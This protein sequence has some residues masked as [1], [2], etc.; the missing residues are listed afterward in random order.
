MEITN[1]Y[2][3]LKR[4]DNKVVSK[5]SKDAHRI[6]ITMPPSFFKLLES[7]FDNVKQITDPSLSQ[8]TSQGTFVVDYNG[9]KVTCNYVYQFVYSTCY[10][11]VSVDL[12]KEI[13]IEVLDI[14]NLKLL[15]LK[16]ELNKY[17]ISIISYDS[18]SEFYCDKLYPFFNEF[19][20]KLRN[21]L[22]LIYTTNFSLNYYLSTT[23]KELQ[24]KISKGTKEIKKDFVNYSK[25]EAKIKFA[26]YTL[27]YSDIENLL[28][29]EHVLDDDQIY[30][31]QF[32]K[33]DVD[34]S[35]L[36]EEQIRLIIN[37]GIIKSDWD[38]YF[39]DKFSTDFKSVLSNL[40]KYSNSI[41]HCKFVTK[42]Q[43]N[44]CLKSIKEAIKTVDRA[45][46]LT[47]ENDFKSKNVTY[48]TGSIT[49]FL[50]SLSEIFTPVMDNM[51][52]ISNTLSDGAKLVSNLSKIPTSIFQNDITNNILLDDDEENAKNT[53]KGMDNISQESTDINN[54]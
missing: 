1:S 9:K 37:K 28:F 40:Q 49:A 17:Y 7:T 53:N 50:K 29:T 24:D 27:T 3:F 21:L 43:Y 34:L 11:D 51:T 8:I 14:I 10:L 48:I 23:S 13:S 30:L 39:G 5:S 31:K 4:T 12:S 46:Q 47:Q 45:I 18:V 26:F 42:T 35:A 20:R 32:I 19:E 36:S 41:A 38:I 54:N 52:T 25:D 44:D 16:G 33:D 22:F 15:D 6:I 2:I